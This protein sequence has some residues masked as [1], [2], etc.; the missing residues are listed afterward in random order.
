MSKLIADRLSGIPAGDGIC[1]VNDIAGDVQ[2]VRN[3]TRYD[4]SRAIVDIEGSTHSDWVDISMACG[5]IKFHASVKHESFGEESSRDSFEWNIQKCIQ[6]RAIIVGGLRNG[7]LVFGHKILN[8]GD[9][10]VEA[11]RSLC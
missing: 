7:V 10:L 4:I 11:Y 6:K 9:D 2:W 8:A 1:F 3:L 5:G